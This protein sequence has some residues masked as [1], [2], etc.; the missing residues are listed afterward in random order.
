MAKKS[1]RVR[2]K[3]EGTRLSEKQMAQPTQVAAVA[4]ATTT[5]PAAQPDKQA[6]AADLQQEYQYVV[7]D[8]KRLGLLA[9][10]ILGSMLILYIIL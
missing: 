3:G 4:P 5:V 10:A 1:R 8:L 2:R 9:A 7:S 6:A